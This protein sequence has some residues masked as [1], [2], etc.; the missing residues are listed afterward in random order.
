MDKIWD[1]L[2]TPKDEILTLSR[3]YDAPREL[4]FNAW[5][6]CKHISNWFGPKGWSLSYC[7][8]DPRP[9]GLFLYCM[10]GPEGDEH[11]G[12][13]VFHEIEAPGRL[14]FINSFSDEYGGLERV[15]FMPEW[16]REVLVVVT[17]TE[18][19]GKTTLTFESAPVNASE[20]EREIFLG[21][22]EQFGG[23]WGSSLERLGELVSR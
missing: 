18:D 3:T 7:K 2:K 9:G 8:V 16:P 17:F 11:W 21:G 10:R 15:A 19:A 23:G 1:H 20:K 12:R 14:V 13:L 5:T 22:K 4:V 6:D